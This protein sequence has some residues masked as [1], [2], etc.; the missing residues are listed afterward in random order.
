M[1]IK[2][3]VHSQKNIF[4]AN[5][6]LE[7]NALDEEWILLPNKDKGYK[8][9]M[10]WLHSSNMPEDEYNM[11][12]DVF[13]YSVQ[14]L[15]A[16]TLVGNIFVAKQYLADGIPLLHQLKAMWSNLST[17]HKKGL[18]SLFCRIKKLGYR[19]YSSHHD[20]TSK[21]LNKETNNHLDPLKGSLSD[22]EFDSFISVI[23]KKIEN[24]NWFIEYDFDFYKSQKFSS[25]S[26]AISAKLLTS[27]I[28]R[29]VQLQRMKWSDLIPLTSSF[30]EKR[31]VT[32]DMAASLGKPLLQVRVY[33]AKDS[34]SG[35]REQPEKYGIPLHERLS[36]EL[37]N[38]KK[39]YAE[40]VKLWL[41]LNGHSVNE[42]QLIKLLQNMPI[43]LHRSLFELKVNSIDE[44]KEVFTDKSVAFH[45]NSSSIGKSLEQHI[46]KSER[47]AIAK[48]TS[49]R[50]RHTILTRGARDGLSK[51]QLAKIT[52]VTMQAVQSYIDM[53]FKTRTMID[54]RY[55][56][57]SFLKKAFNSPISELDFN[58]HYIYDNDF[59]VVGEASSQT[60]CN[61]CS[62]KLGRP[63][64][65]Y[66]CENFKPFLEA[67]HRAVLS[68][69]EKKRDVNRTALIAPLQ[70]HS[71]E[72][73]NKQITLINYTI[74]LCDDMLLKRVQANV[75]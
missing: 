32:H 18:N 71:L 58:G 56:G 72:K 9:E 4:I 53:D 73:L 65:C 26:Y 10:G 33:I 6:G 57:N 15:S 24:F 22:I 19:A 50:L 47:V 8:I 74:A 44:I 61:R 3:L 45:V 46:I 29:P 27:I 40:G 52:G 59:N 63:L 62:T 25:I 30:N 20:F 75:E 49:N 36:N 70:S 51:P 39:L 67:D 7:I 43:F 23:N 11:M 68:A 38:F 54:K 55:I 28:R 69:A 60:S 14:K 2:R 37:L 42:K 64:G 13:K 41:E 34:K 16:S 5:S 66:G 12:L 21:H 17:G 48:A 35:I 31:I 1:G